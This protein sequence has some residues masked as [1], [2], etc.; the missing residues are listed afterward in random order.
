MAKDRV[1][2][3]NVSVPRD[4][5]ARM[6][7]TKESV[8]WSGVAAQAFEGKLLEIKSRKGGKEMN[9]VIA[10]LKAAAELEAN[11]LYQAGF[12]AGQDW[13][14]EKATPKQLRRLAEYAADDESREGHWASEAL[15]S[16]VW[17]DP[18]DKLSQSAPEDFWRHALGDKAA[19]L[20]EDDDFHRGFV[21]GALDLWRRVRTKL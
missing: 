8:N 7:N 20:V 18:E 12:K 17:P 1:I 16:A 15:V 5:K 11:R 21:E 6:D 9:E 14:S 3:M 13:A 19:E 10:R 4:L 2:R